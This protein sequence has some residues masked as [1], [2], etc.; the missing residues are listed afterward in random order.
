[1]KVLLYEISL[2][3]PSVNLRMA[4]RCVALEMLNAF[5]HAYI[6]T[7]IHIVELC[8]GTDIKMNNSRTGLCG[9]KFKYFSS[10]G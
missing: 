7:Y 10:V 1:M 6:H 5:I 9:E 3:P 8:G 4:L 2:T